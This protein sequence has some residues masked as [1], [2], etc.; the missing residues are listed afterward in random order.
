M[1]VAVASSSQIGSW[2][3]LFPTDL[4]TEVHS[5]V[6][7]KKF[8]AVAVSY[9][10]YTRHLFPESAFFDKHLEVKSCHNIFISKNLS[11]ELINNDDPY[12][13]CKI[14]E[15]YSFKMDYTNAAMYLNIFKQKWSCKLVGTSNEEIKAATINLLKTI[16]TAGQKL[17]KLPVNL[18][19]TMR[20]QYYDG[21][22]L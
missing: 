18:Y 2:S 17:L 7:V 3:K 11:N 14:V 4:A 19:M 10:L 15:S 13:A 16:H 8:F 22:P 6:F 12:A 20:L 5:L 21:E 1:A 9:V